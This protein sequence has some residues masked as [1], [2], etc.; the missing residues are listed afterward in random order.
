MDDITK[1]ISEFVSKADAIKNSGKPINE[2]SQ[3]LIDV[4][5]RADKAA[6]SLKLLYD[7]AKNAD[8]VD[9]QIQNNASPD[10]WQNKIKAQNDYNAQ[11]AYTQKLLKELNNLSSQIENGVLSQEQRN[12]VDNYLKNLGD[13]QN[14]LRALRANA[15]TTDIIGKEDLSGDFQNIQNLIDKLEEIRN[16]TGS[17]PFDY[18][19]T[20]D[21][22][23]ELGKAFESATIKA[24]ALNAESREAN[25]D[26]SVNRSLEKM[27]D[28][29]TKAYEGS[30]RLKSNDEETKAFKEMLDKMDPSLV[31]TNADVRKLRQETNDLISAWKNSGKMLDTF[32]DKTAST[33]IKFVGLEQVF[34]RIAGVVRSMVSRI[35]DDVKNLDAA[36]TELR[37]VTDANEATYRNFM[38]TAKETASSI[39]AGLADVVTSTADFA[40]LGYDI[41]DAQ[42]LA[43]A[44]L[45][46]KNVGDGI[47]DVNVASESL[48]ST[49]KAFGIEAE[50]A[51][52]IVDRFNET[53]NKFAISSGGVGDA[54]SK[55]AAALSVAGNSLDESIALI[56]AANAVV[57]NPESVGTAM[58]TLT[59]YL[60]AAKTEAEE[61]GESTDGMAI[62][63]AK[64]REDIQALSD[65]DIMLDEN[66]FKSTYQIISEISE[67][68]NTMFDVDK[69]NLLNLLGGKRNANVLSG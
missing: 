1:S 51:M 35:I 12:F 11:L 66:T 39:G 34:M 15:I 24:R 13:A 33:I 43:K 8:G 6:Q 4:A 26:A 49:M 22:V 10:Q 50:D 14:K 59:M 61:A 55:S 23:L 38:K 69:A 41:G 58:K 17:E 21:V 47:T 68:W 25:N 48:I 46:Y 30:A 28:D 45:V 9:K 5:E 44:A 64:L 52:M 42:N 36:M 53:G 18:K 29:L 54:L 37:K 27:R 2:E 56:T 57:Q 19:N 16:K 31:K 7:A 32:K 63:V 20:L 67:A 40:R 3:A 60:R 65:V 62:S